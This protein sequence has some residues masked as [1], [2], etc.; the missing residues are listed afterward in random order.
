MIWPRN[1][2]RRWKKPKT[3]GDSIVPAGQDSSSG[4]SLQFAGQLPMDS[5][6]FI[7]LHVSFKPHGQS[8]RQLPQL[9]SPLQLPSPQ[10]GHAPQ[11]SSQE[12]QSSTRTSQVPLPQGSH[13]PQSV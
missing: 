1:A 11:S 4:T 12:M 10:V 3:R 6:T 5:H 7:A 13:S 2:Q 8:S 9:S